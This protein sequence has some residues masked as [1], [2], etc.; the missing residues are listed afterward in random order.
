[1]EKR[2][3]PQVELEIMQLMDERKSLLAEIATKKYC[4]S[5]HGFIPEVTEMLVIHNEARGFGY[6]NIN[7]GG[8]WDAD[9]LFDSP[10]DAL[11]NYRAYVQTQV[12]R[13]SGTA[14]HLDKL[15]EENLR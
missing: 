13:W 3:I 5:V 4:V 1:M 2:T 6:V 14:F 15:I 9:E 8:S 7:D 11:N 10:I 12:E